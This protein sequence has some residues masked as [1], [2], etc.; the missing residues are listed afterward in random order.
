MIEEFMEQFQ[1]KINNLPDMNPEDAL[2]M[3]EMLSNMNPEEVEQTLRNMFHM[4]KEPYRKKFE[5]NRNDFCSCKSNLKYKNC[6]K[7]SQ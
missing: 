3:E 5:Q 1:D 2:L 4:K 6:C 7:K